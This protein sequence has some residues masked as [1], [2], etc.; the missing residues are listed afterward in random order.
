MNQYTKEKWIQ[1]GNKIKSPGRGTIAICPSPTTSEGVLEFI[2]NAQ[3]ISACPDLYEACKAQ[4]DAIDILLARLIELDH[5][6]FPSKSGKPWEAI[7]QGNK[8]LAK[9]EV[10]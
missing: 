1:E 5:N 3:L 7:I 9:V 2:A 6:F 4:H 10:I 8:A